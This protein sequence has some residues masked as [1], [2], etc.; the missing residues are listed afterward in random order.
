MDS[1][2]ASRIIGESGTGSGLGQGNG[3]GRG[4]IP[5]GGRMAGAGDTTTLITIMS[6]SITLTFITTG[7][8]ALCMSGITMV[9]MR[10]TAGSGRTIGALT[11]TRT[12][13]A[14]LIARVSGGL[15]ATTA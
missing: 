8:P 13:A 1:G 2:W 6:V 12:P 10:G 3:W 14:P 9:S 7:D 15:A 11:S 5:G 4:V